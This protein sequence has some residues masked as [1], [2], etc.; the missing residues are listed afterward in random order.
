MLWDR[1]HIYIRNVTHPEINWDVNRASTHMMVTDKQID[2][3]IY[4]IEE[5]SKEK[6]L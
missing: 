2:K 5:I 6:Q 3:L 4:V 1:H